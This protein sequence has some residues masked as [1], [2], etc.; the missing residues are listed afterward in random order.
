MGNGQY[1]WMAD[2]DYLSHHPDYFKDHG[3]FDP[4]TDPNAADPGA[5]MAYPSRL[6]LQPQGDVLQTGAVTFKDY[7]P[8]AAH[9]LAIDPARGFIDSWN[10]RPSHGWWAND[11]DGSWGPTHRVAML[12]K[13]LA[14]FQASGKKFNYANMVNIMSDAAYTD[15]RGQAV[16][17]LL[18]KIM[19]DV[20]AGAAPLTTDQKKVITLM[21]NWLD[22]AP[23]GTPNPSDSSSW[24]G[25]PKDTD[26]GA[27]RRDTHADNPGVY[28]QQ[29]AVVLMDAWYPEL[30]KTMLPQVTA[31]D[32]CNPATGGGGGANSGFSLQGCYDAPRAQ[33]SAFQHGW[34]E[35][36]RRVL[37]M[38]LGTA[39]HPYRALKCG[40]KGEGSLAACRTAVLTALSSALNTLGGVANE[41][42]WD[43]TQLPS[44]QY[45]T[46]TGHTVEDYDSII[47]TDFSLLGVPNMPWENRPT[48][49]QVV[50]VR[51]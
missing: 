38:S 10:N 17:P 44:A 33:G 9:P 3:G 26:L 28:D 15:L 43:G 47:F 8:M 2:A 1:D 49:Q 34:F 27:F 36:M 12:G 24:I 30:A 31:I 7:L 19:Q 16:L 29:A 32:S 35:M 18:L 20:P 41:A 50:E 39:N 42:N 13:R 6:V 21:Q 14:A 22:G 46:T 37:K 4:A 51:N 5:S 11:S 23:N 45:G 48:F 40:G 25:G